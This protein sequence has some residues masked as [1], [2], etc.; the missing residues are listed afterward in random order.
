MTAKEVNAALAEMNIKSWQ[1]ARAMGISEW[2]FSVWKRD[3][4]IRPDRAER[5]QT[6]LD[7]MRANKA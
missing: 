2:T 5:I 4:P 1:A 7:A 6:M 3:E